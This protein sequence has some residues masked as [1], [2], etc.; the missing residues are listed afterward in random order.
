M[1]ETAL[2]AEIGE[3]SLQMI[4][5]DKKGNALRFFWWTED[6]KRNNSRLMDDIPPAWCSTVIQF[7]NLG[8]AEENGN[9]RGA[10]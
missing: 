4:V 5:L 1:S 6:D 7:S 8:I 10:K 3:T 2:S 9:T